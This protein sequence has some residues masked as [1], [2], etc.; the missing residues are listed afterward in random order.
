MSLEQIAPL[1]QSRHGKMSFVYAIFVLGLD[2]VL[3]SM[4]AV[5]RWTAH[6]PLSR[7]YDLQR[8]SVRQTP[9]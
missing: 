2:A 8:R 4:L 3:F 1:E 7:C 6:S 5:L 9:R